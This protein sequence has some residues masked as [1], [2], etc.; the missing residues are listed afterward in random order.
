MKIAYL[1]CLELSIEGGVLKK[2]R[3]QVS[4]WTRLGHEVR[5]YFLSGEPPGFELLSNEY[6]WSPNRPLS[7]YSQKYVNRI[8][9]L[10]CVKIELMKLSP[11]VLYVRQVLWFPGI[12]AIFKQYKTVVECNTNDLVEIELRPFP[13][14]ILLLILRTLFFK[15]VKG[16]VSVTREL[17]SSFSKNLAFTSLTNSLVVPKELK[18]KALGRPKKIFFMSTPNQPWQGVDK[19][20]EL[21]SHMPETQWTIAGWNVDDIDVEIPKN[22]DIVGFQNSEMISRY[23][24]ESGYAVAP[25][26][27]FRKGMS[28]TSAIK[29]GEYLIANLPIILAYEETGVE[30]DYL[31][32][33]ENSENNVCTDSVRKIERFMDYWQFRDIDVETIR[34]QID[35]DVV[36]CKRLEFLKGLI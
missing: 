35:S 21:A 36:E 4:S 19:I 13:I 33:L 30:G 22:L 3:R 26:A 5:V 10:K 1:V 9:L 6:C 25:L 12:N 31:C 29:V 18:T 7:R 17:K 32:H 14:R 2:I 24:A 15:D 20:I 27:L 11:D 8:Q 34:K 28:S 23:L 16:V